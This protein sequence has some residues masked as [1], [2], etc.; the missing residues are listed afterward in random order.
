MD[1]NWCTFCGTHID[2]ADD[3]LYCSEACRHNDGASQINPLSITRTSSISIKTSSHSEYFSLAS[4]SSSPLASSPKWLPQTLTRERTPS[5]TPMTA[6]DLSAR[7]P[8]HAP[9]YS[10]SRS[11]VSSNFYQSPSFGPSMTDIRVRNSPV[12]FSQLST[13]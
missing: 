10:P 13:M 8:C 7:L 2:C 11:P 5:L 12:P 1:T 9:A 6:L 4:P 3:A